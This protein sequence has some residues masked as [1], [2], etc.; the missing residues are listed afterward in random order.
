VN[1]RLSR[2]ERRVVLLMWLAGLDLMLT[3]GVLLLAH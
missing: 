1:D 3:V 2:I